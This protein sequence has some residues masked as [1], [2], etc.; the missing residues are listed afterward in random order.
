MRRGF[1]GILVLVA[2]AVVGSLGWSA[3]S[4]TFGPP[5]V[6]LELPANPWGSDTG[7]AAVVVRT[8]HHGTPV[9][10]S[11]R[12]RAEGI[13]DGERRS[14]PLEFHRTSSVGV[15]A[16]PQSWPSHGD[17]VLAISGH[18]DAT[19][20]VEL[21]PD[22]GM[23]RENYY[24]KLTQIVSVRSVRVVEGAVSNETIDRMLAEE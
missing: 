20:L 11:M 21:G 15:Y 19:L 4:S 23:M 22:G 5:W 13:V 16:V 1:S 18:P 9:V 7:S 24:G 10:G 3:P 6:S 12:G 2:L 8:Y 14:I 17:W